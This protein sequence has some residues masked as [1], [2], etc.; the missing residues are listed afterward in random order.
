M[1]S[2]SWKIDTGADVTVIPM[3][4]AAGIGLTATR[5]AWIS[6]YD[7]TLSLRPVYYATF[8]FC[9]VS[10]S[11]VRCVES[12]RDIALI[13]RNVLNQ[14]VLVLDGPNLE[15]EVKLP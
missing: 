14:L 2:L 5:Y 10:L 13:G 8:E 9:G 7:G 11:S 4:L 1:R 3:S 15:F 6:A 12:Q